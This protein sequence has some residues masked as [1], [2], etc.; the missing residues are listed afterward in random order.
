MKLVFIVSGELLN[1]GQPANKFRIHGPMASL[2]VNDD[3]K[4]GIYSITPNWTCVPYSTDIRVK[5]VGIIHGMSNAVESIGDDSENHTPCRQLVAQ[6]QTAKS[7]LPLMLTDS[8]IRQAPTLLLQARTDPALASVITEF[9]DMLDTHIAHNAGI[10]DN[11]AEITRGYVDTA[12]HSKAPDARARLAPHLADW[13]TTAEDEDDSRF[14]TSLASCTMAAAV[15]AGVNRRALSADPRTTNRSCKCPHHQPNIT[16]TLLLARYV[17]KYQ[18]AR[19][20]VPTLSE[21]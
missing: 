8:N 10:V 21:T 16:S 1:Y 9:T 20:D 5:L 3:I 13:D 17:C 15:G 18:R 12:L 19:T 4:S 11:A 2:A 7:N 14:T 6:F